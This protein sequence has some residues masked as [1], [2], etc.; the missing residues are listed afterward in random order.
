MFEGCFEGFLRFTTENHVS[1]WCKQ[2]MSGTVGNEMK[3]EEEDDECII[4]DESESS[5]IPV[6]L[7]LMQTAYK[8][9]II[10]SI[11]CDVNKPLDFILNST[12]KATY[13]DPLMAIYRCLESQLKNDVILPYNITDLLNK[14][15]GFEK[16]HDIK[17]R[18]RLRRECSDEDKELC[19]KL[20]I[21]YYHIV[22]DDNFRN[23]TYTMFDQSHIDKHIIS[24]NGGHNKGARI[25]NGIM[26]YQGNACI[27]CKKNLEIVYRN[28]NDNVKGSTAIAHHKTSAPKLCTSYQKK[29]KD[30]DIYYNYN[31]IDYTK[32]A[33]NEDRRNATLWLDPEA[34]PYYSLAG[35]SVRNFVHK[36]IHRSIRNHQYCKKPTSISTWLEHYND[37]FRA[38]YNELLKIEGVDELLRNTVQL[39]YTFTLRYFYLYSLLCRIRDLENYGSIDINGRS[40]KIA[41][42]TTDKD[43]KDM[44][45]ELALLN[46]IKDDE[47]KNDEAKDDGTTNNNA[48]DNETMNDKAKGDGTMKENSKVRSGQYFA[49]YFNKY[50]EQL[51]KTAVNELKEVPVRINTAGEIEIYPGWFIIYGDGGEKITRL[52]CAYPA[53]LSKLDYI[54]E[55]KKDHPNEKVIINDIEK[56]NDDIDLAINNDAAKYSAQRYYEC[57]A[58]PCYN[59]HNNKKKSYKCCKNHIA[60]IVDHFKDSKLGLKL[61]HVT[62]FITWYQL[63]AALAK[64]KNTNVRKTITSLYTID[65]EVLTKITTKQ[66]KKMNELELKAN[67]YAQKNQENQKIFE[68]FV[69]YIHNKINSYRGGRARYDRK[70]KQKGTNDA[71]SNSKLDQKQK[72]YDKLRKIFGDDDF[73]TG[74]IDEMMEDNQTSVIDLLNLEFNYNKYLDKHG[75]CRRSH[76]ISGATIARTKGL[77]VFLNCAGIIIVL[78]EEI[79][80]ETP[81][82]VILDIADS[83]TNNRTIKKYANRIEAIGYDMICRIYHH[84]KTLIKKERLPANQEVFWCDMMWRAFIDIWHIYTHTDELCK[85]DGTF[86]PKLP[87]FEKILYDINTMMDRVNDI[88]AE[89]FW[90]TMNATSQLKSMGREKFAFFLME[91]RA[92]HN[93]VKYN[94]IKNNGWTFIPIEWCTRLRNID[95]D[96]KYKS[97]LPSETELKDKNNTPLER[98]AINSMYMQDVTRLIS[99]AKSRNNTP[100]RITKKRKWTVIESSTS[101]RRKMSNANVEK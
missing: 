32:N 41:L 73:D 17:L 62:E 26:M 27:E 83:C 89:Q 54:K 92:Y 71:S 6:T 1:F 66:Q 67:L 48:K 9:Y 57:A 19:R 16:A 99:K 91:K 63:N 34:F 30:C 75:G 97:S 4:D 39:G 87:K 40:V 93:E 20:S 47:N 101:K 11:S 69:E 28:S 45:E 53:I 58:S 82:A 90:S 18:D 86:H 59:D 64:M 76:N 29:C 8:F 50:Y 61:C 43:K 21:I 46:N 36:S 60:K 85:K 23:M 80:R 35:K 31:K 52:R 3:Q 56:D 42:I 37:D 94:E 74:V 15:K 22:F 2:T 95:K 10:K 100:T 98:V 38:E 24:L 65:E 79:V 49:F 77:N 81:T 33:I 55:Q 72:F 68:N 13:Q 78:R 7:T 25:T 5:K 70:C 88:I 12:A 51:L 96:T 44:E 84:L 14:L